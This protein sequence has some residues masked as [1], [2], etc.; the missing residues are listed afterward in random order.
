[1][2]NILHRPRY[3]NPW[4]LVGSHS[5]RKFGHLEGRVFLGGSHWRWASV[6]SSLA[7]LSV[8]LCVTYMV[9]CGQLLSCHHAFPDGCRTFLTMMTKINPF[10]P[11]FFIIAVLNIAV[12]YHNR[13]GEIVGKLFIQGWQVAPRIEECC[14]TDTFLPHGLR[15][16]SLHPRNPVLQ[17]WLVTVAPRNTREWSKNE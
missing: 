1:M 16:C 14:S 4:S 13:I 7:P 12:F 15:V 9:K 2:R 17:P 6:V 10:F 8:L 11:K 5:V 3:L